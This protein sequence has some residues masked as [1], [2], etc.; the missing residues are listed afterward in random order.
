MSNGVKVNPYRSKGK[1]VCSAGHSYQGSLYLHQQIGCLCGRCNNQTD[2]GKKIISHRGGVVKEISYK[3][4]RPYFHI[5]CKNGHE[6]KH[7]VSTLKQG[8]FCNKCKLDEY[9]FHRSGAQLTRE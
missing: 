2:L 8:K 6:F 1:I 7:M 4:K 9:G 3:G 5:I